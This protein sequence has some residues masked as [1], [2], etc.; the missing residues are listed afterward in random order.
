M[1]K[2]LICLTILVFV[3][4][5]LSVAA[6]SV[7]QVEASGTIYILATGE[8]VGTDKISRLGDS[9]YKF[10]DS[11][12][13]SIVVERSNIVIDGDG[14]ILDGVDFSIMEGLNLTD[15]SN[16][17]IVDITFQ[18]FA[19]YSIYLDS[20]SDCVISGNTV[21]GSEGGIGLFSSTGNTVT[22]NEITGSVLLQETLFQGTT[23]PTTTPVSTLLLVPQ[24]TQSPKTAL[25]PT[26]LQA[27][28]S[29]VSPT[30]T[31]YLATTSRLARET[32]TFTAPPTTR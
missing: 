32:S 21:V 5:G 13:D 31:S 11:I 19:S 22:D 9:Y 10:N 14:W 6:I 20:A 29:Q 26:L 4:M 2:K 27:S 28:L 3:L 16:V 18:G 15:V 7:Y 1:G 17:T 25:Q 24:K 30:P 8:V 12:N 23:S